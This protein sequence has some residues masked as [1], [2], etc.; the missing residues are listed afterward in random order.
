MRTFG[1]KK[2]KIMNNT[3][4]SDNQPNAAEPSTVFGT[5]EHET[6]YGFAIPSSSE[7]SRIIIAVD[8]LSY[9]RDGWDGADAPS[10][11]TKVIENIKNIVDLCKNNDLI[12]WNIE[13]NIN[14][15]IL[16]R[17]EDAAI[18]LGADMFSYY[19][20]V[21]NKVSGKNKLVFS[22]AAVIDTIRMIN[23]KR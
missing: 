1:N 3:I 12:G 14:G 6:S 13:P 16:L 4:P 23:Y 22:T 7:K 2:A 17:Y 9:M 19:F 20:K 11:N 8:K 18:S 21:G 10:I 15:T 5:V